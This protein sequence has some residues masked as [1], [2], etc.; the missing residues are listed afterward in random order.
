M[1]CILMSICCLI[2]DVVVADNIL[3]ESKGLS[4]VAFE[5]VEDVSIPNNCEGF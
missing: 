5:G 3:G 4:V 1:S 2:K